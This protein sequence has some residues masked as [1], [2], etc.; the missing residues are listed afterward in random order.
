MVFAQKLHNFLGKFVTDKIIYC[1]CYKIIL[2]ITEAQG[3][4]IIIIR[5]II[6]ETLS[7]VISY[8]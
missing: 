8:K 3:Y 1:Q 6:I 7:A 2:R 4:S 5:R